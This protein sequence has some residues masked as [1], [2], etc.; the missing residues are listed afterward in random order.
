MSINGVG[1]TLLA[2]PCGLVYPTIMGGFHAFSSILTAL[3][4]SMYGG[5]VVLYIGASLPFWGSVLLGGGQRI[6]LV[7]RGAV[8]HGRY[9][10]HF[11]AAVIH[12]SPAYGTCHSSLSL[13][14]KLLRP[15]PCS[16][17][18]WAQACCRAQ[19]RLYSSMKRHRLCTNAGASGDG[20]SQTCKQCVWCDALRLFTDTIHCSSPLHDF[21]LP[22]PP[23]Y[24]LW[25]SLMLDVAKYLVPAL[26]FRL[27][28]SHIS[29][30]G[31][32]LSP[33]CLTL[34]RPSPLWSA[35]LFYAELNLSSLSPRQPTLSFMPVLSPLAAVHHLHG[36]R[37][38][39]VCLGLRPQFFMGIMALINV[40][41]S[42]IGNNALQGSGG[43][44]RSRQRSCTPPRVT[45]RYRS[46]RH[47]Y[48]SKR[49]SSTTD[50]AKMK[51]FLYPGCFF[52]LFFMIFFFYFSY[53]CRMLLRI[54]GISHLQ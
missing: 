21:P 51:E 24:A 30:R 33:V 18:C 15:H 31:S 50:A 44:S 4:R 52:R 53:S 37:F 13:S 46:Q 38:R 45:A 16:A 26:L 23:P 42:L 11:F 40:S 43:L 25:M 32:V 27:L 7:N 8:H 19:R 9:F 20:I 47:D 28:W 39:R 14:A 17:V 35:Y 10:I 48:G 41:A 29:A 34:F 6:S 49:Y 5:A 54:T 2:V 1:A 36:A 12:R 3:S 22:P